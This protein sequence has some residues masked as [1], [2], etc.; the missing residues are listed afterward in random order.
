MS[1]I[2]IEFVS[3]SL[4]HPVITLHCKTTHAPGT[5]PLSPMAVLFLASTDGSTAASVQ[6]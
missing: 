5:H 6:I 2:V 4:F 1:S 3:L